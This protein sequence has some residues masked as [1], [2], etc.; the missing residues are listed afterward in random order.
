MPNGPSHESSPPT[1]A[2]IYRQIAIILREGDDFEKQS[3]EL[4]KLLEGLDYETLAR[5][6]ELRLVAIQ[7]APGED[8]ARVLVGLRRSRDVVE[9]AEQNRVLRS[10]WVVDD[11]LYRHQWALGRIGAEP[12]WQH[13]L[14]TLNLAAPGVIVAIIDSGI[15]TRHPD[16]AGHLWSDGAGHHGRNLLTNSFDVSDTD[17]HGT[18]LAGT[19]GAISNNAAGIA[20]AE[21]P[22]RLMAV[23]FLDVR[24]PPTALSGALAIF[25]AV[26]HGAQVITA[27]WAVGIPSP[28]LRI[29]IWFANVAGVVFIAAAGNDGLDNDVSPTYPAGYGAPAFALPNVVSVMASERPDY[30]AIA[31]ADARDDKAWF[32]N[33]GKTS[34]HLA[35]PGVGILST[36]TYFGTPQWRAYSGTSPACAHVAYAAALLKA[37]NPA[38]TPV[39]IRDHLVASVDKSPWLACVAKGR[40]SLDRAVVGPFVI[41]SPLA[42]AQWQAATNR[43]VSWTLRYSTPLATSVRILLSRDGGAYTTIATGPNSGSCMVMAPS[44]AVASARL[45]IQSEQGPGLYAQSGVFSVVVAA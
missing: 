35:A 18:L 5:V 22:I 16:L 10:S 36:Q 30:L 19:V 31:A 34:V 40:L 17:G 7:L 14:A 9:T 6:P 11:P 27:A 43:P 42:G 1:Y 39:N 12:A 4:H 44:N 33:Y 45:R 28:V 38:W 24:N 3:R 15:H 29:A 32:S 37:M 25:W 41:T 8:V 23:K 26:T 13:A 20:A 21:W 2:E